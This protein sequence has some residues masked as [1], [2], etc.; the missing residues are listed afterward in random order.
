MLNSRGIGSC[1]LDDAAAGDERAAARGGE[2][3]AAAVLPRGLALRR[4][5]A[6]GRG[7]QMPIQMP[8][9]FHFRDD[10]PIFDKL[11]LPHEFIFSPNM[12]S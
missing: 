4:T 12:Q 8:R 6:L 9:A 2:V 10:F 11:I 1:D 3:G 5:R 7:L